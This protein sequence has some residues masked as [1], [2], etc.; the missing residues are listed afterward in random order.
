M[1]EPIWIALLLIQ[2]IIWLVPL[3]QLFKRVVHLAASE[4]PRT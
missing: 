2:P 1:R 4:Q 3:R